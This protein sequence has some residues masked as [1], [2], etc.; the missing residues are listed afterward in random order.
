MDPHVLAATIS[1]SGSV[2]LAILGIARQIYRQRY[3]ARSLQQV[4]RE[5]KA[6]P[7]MRLEDDD[8][9]TV[10]CHDAVKADLMN[11]IRRNIV[12][13]PT[14]RELESL[15][16]RVH[17]QGSKLDAAFIEE[18][19]VLVRDQLHRCQE[20]EVSY[21]PVAIHCIIRRLTVLHCDSLST[22]SDLFTSSYSVGQLMELVFNVFYVSTFAALSQWAQT[23]NQINGQLNGLMWEGRRIGYSFTGNVTD[24]LRILNPALSLMHDALGETDSCVFL[25]NRSGAILGCCGSKACFG[26]S[27]QTLTSMSLSVLQL[28]LEDL[29][30]ARDLKCFQEEVGADSNDDTVYRSFPIK[31][32]DEKTWETTAFSFR[33]LLSSP[34][35]H[36]VSVVLFV[37]NGLAEPRAEAQ[38]S[39][40]PELP[41]SSIEDAHT[42]LAFVMSALTNPVRRVALGCSLESGV[43]L[44]QG[45]MDGS[46]D[47]PHFIPNRTLH[48]QMEVQQRRIHDMCKRCELRLQ[49]DLLRSAS[50]NYVWHS[51]FVVAEFYLIG[52]TQRALMT[53]HFPNNTALSAAAVQR[54]Q[55]ATASAPRANALTR[56]RSLFSLPCIRAQT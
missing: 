38:E 7:V 54:Q 3:S 47:L 30:P 24:A 26:F 56:R 28:G 25:V 22:A 31:A 16:L 21:F 43:P 18:S 12:C 17:A 10:F 51:A 33:V 13:I 35:P 4:L 29:N 27:S 41:A 44:V 23:A 37:R 52:K 50:L 53:I 40:A 15:L 19:V 34:E 46:P 6:H 39:E 49:N 1:A 5:L 11:A 9:L 8:A 55:T 20:K 42:R 14:K 45:V 48:A 32:H 2:A 36:K